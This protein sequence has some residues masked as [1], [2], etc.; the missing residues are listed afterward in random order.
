MPV[1]SWSIRRLASKMTA[2]SR[3]PG[4]DKQDLEDQLTIMLSDF[5]YVNKIEVNHGLAQPLV[6]KL[7][8][9]AEVQLELIKT[10]RKLEQ[11]KAKHKGD[12]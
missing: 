4:I 5:L 6:S 7:Q 8:K 11:L 9:Q 12:K 3:K 2:R 10:R 1:K